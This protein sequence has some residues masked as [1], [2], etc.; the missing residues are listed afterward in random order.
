MITDGTNVTTVSNDGTRITGADD[1]AANYTLDGST[2]DDG[3]GNIAKNT[4][5]GSGFEDKDGNIGGI[6]ATGAEFAE[7]RTATPT[8]SKPT[9]RI[10][11][12]WTDARR[13]TT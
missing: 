7:T 5:L 9:V 6:S 12:M 3:Q 4:A 10:L 1:K 8:K 2:I 13:I 11:A